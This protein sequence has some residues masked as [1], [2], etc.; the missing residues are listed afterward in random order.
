MTKKC[1]FFLLLFFLYTPPCAAQRVSRT[2]RADAKSRYQKNCF[3][4]LKGTSE[5]QHLPL[6]PSL[7]G[8]PDTIV[9]NHTLRSDEWIVGNFVVRQ[10]QIVQGDGTLPTSLL[11]D[12]NFLEL[13]YD[14]PSDQP[15]TVGVKASTRAKNEKINQEALRV[16]DQSRHVVTKTAVDLEKDRRDFPESV[17]SGLKEAAPRHW[18]ATI[19]EFRNRDTGEVVGSMR[20]DS[21]GPDRRLLPYPQF[22]KDFL[23]TYKGEWKRSNDPSVTSLTKPLILEEILSKEVGRPIRVERPVLKIPEGLTLP[24]GEIIYELVGEAK[25]IGAL[26]VKKDV[27]AE[28]FNLLTQ[29]MLLSLF[30]PNHSKSYNENGQIFYAWGEKTGIRLW[31]NGMGFEQL[32]PEAPFDLNGQNWWLMR[33]T[34]QTMVK[35]IDGIAKKPTTSKAEEERLRYIL[36]GVRGTDLTDQNRQI[37]HMYYIQGKTQPEIAKIFEVSAAKVSASLKSSNA[38]LDVKVAFPYYDQEKFHA[39]AQRELFEEAVNYGIRRLGNDFGTKKLILKLADLLPDSPDKLALINE[40]NQESWGWKEF[41]GQ[42]AKKGMGKSNQSIYFALYRIARVLKNTPRGARLDLSKL[43]EA[44]EFQKFLSA[45]DP[46]RLP[47]LRNPDHKMAFM[48]REGG[49]FRL[50]RDFGQLLGVKGTYRGSNAKALMLK[51]LG[52][53]RIPDS[54]VK[55]S[56]MAE[57]ENR[58][59]PNHIQAFR[60]Q[61]GTSAISR[62][63]LESFQEVYRALYG[64]AT[65]AKESPGG[66]DINPERIWEVAEVQK[67]MAFLHP[68]LPR[69][70]SAFIPPKT[71]SRP[72]EFDNDGQ[73]VL[74]SSARV[75]GNSFSNEFGMRDFLFNLT[76]QLPEGKEKNKVQSQLKN[77]R[78][79]AT[80]GLNLFKSLT[81]REKL[82][83]AVNLIAS[84]LKKSGKAPQLDL[85]KLHTAAEM[86]KFTDLL[87]L[88]VGLAPL[89]DTNKDLFLDPAKGSFSEFPAIA[90]S[91]GISRFT[92]SGLQNLM[93]ELLKR[94][95]TQSEFREK[96][97][98]A[99]SDADNWGWKKND[100]AQVREGIQTAV[101]RAYRALIATAT[102]GRG[103]ELTPQEVSRLC[104]AE[105]IHELV[106]E[107]QPQQST[108]GISLAAPLEP[109]RLKE[110]EH[111]GRQVLVSVARTLGKP[112]VKPFGVRD[113]IYKM[114]EQLP[115]GPDKR[116][117]QA[118]LKS[119]RW[120][121]NDGAHAFDPAGEGVRQR[122]FQAAHLIASALKKSGKAP[123]VDLEKLDTAAEMERFT[124]LLML[125]ASL[126][127]LTDAN[128][129]LF[130]DP[131]KGSLRELSTI[132]KSLGIYRFR[133][134]YGLQNLMIELL[135]RSHTQ[136][137]FRE[138][139]I[140][141]VSDADSWGW[142]ENDLKGAEEGFQPAMT[143][144]YRALIATAMVVRGRELTS[145]EASHLCTAEG[146][147]ELFREI[148]KAGK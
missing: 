67:L 70:E 118:S 103:R 117:V 5:S 95:Q 64:I 58:Q 47:L 143:R 36:E 74:V 83:K 55:Q 2:S 46:N 148:Q 130:L 68:E 53:P 49:A 146:I 108:R 122:T 114:A 6:A 88:G 99:V 66:R 22:L 81:A 147:N 116:E 3:D 97:I 4:I 44:G 62:R 25:E 121:A 65:L 10:K 35:W 112:F 104:T 54:F 96:I 139:I 93:I 30:N 26:S 13:S 111:G 17:L 106:R 14:V 33:H 79:N 98:K 59:W 101:T 38:Q 42:D 15:G 102:V 110:F 78:W 142:K 19:F 23:S 69:I 137:E 124:D 11:R 18:D 134:S 140:K 89:T 12:E 29:Q 37:W 28:V 91:L 20:I 132:A 8:N 40:L 107:I 113:L 77:W 92:Q 144:A 128:K 84:A 138:K 86:E 32:H 100:V 31:S 129:T 105:G 72:K 127:P 41:A 7:K 52:S 60:A 73:Q 27:N 48:N 126:A 51:I 135:K 80:D 76:E 71:R 43:H 57:I 120:L 21:S 75:R 125:G 16:L 61:T 39:G 123:Q 45:L 63:H 90:K 141:A 87:T 133:S 85:E 82:F 56:L 9:A 24:N 34:P 119:W 145:Q 109:E 1:T 131:H 115:E 50:I 94:S 136:S